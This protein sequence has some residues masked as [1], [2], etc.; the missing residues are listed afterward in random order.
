MSKQKTAHT[1][2]HGDCRELSVL[3][4]NSVD[5]IITSPPYWQLKDYGG[6]NQIGF[7][8]TYEEYINNLN[9]A[10]KE[11]H[12]VLDDGCRLCI[13][14]GDQFARSVYYGRYKVIPIHSEIIRFCETIGFDFMGQIIWQKTTTTNTTGG[15][16]IMG[17]FPYPRNGII[18]L[19]FEYI[20]LFKKQGN[21]KKPTLEQKEGARMTVAEW[22]SYFTGHWNFPGARQ[23]AHLAMFPEELPRRLIKMF[24]FPNETV[25]DPFAGSGTVA[26]VAK[27]LGRNSVSCEINEEYIPLIEKKIGLDFFSDIRNIS[28]TLPSCAELDAKIGELP[29]I[30][31]DVHELDKKTDVKKMPYGSKISAD[32]E[33]KRKDLFSVRRVI[34]TELLQLNNDVVVKLIGVKSDESNAAE[35]VRFLSDKFKGKRVFLKHDAVKYDSENHLLA[36]LY[37]ENKTFINAHLLK[38]KFAHV[39][40]SVP[41]G[42]L[43]KFNSLRYGGM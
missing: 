4:N 1:I 33:A 23:D 30:F 14:V 35:A 22:N 3:P 6:D 8:D 12:R 11:C 18:K 16:S 43:Q 7:N 24:S 15:A 9:V 17:S 39:D 37:L 20:L 21:A 32:S 27:E 42:L 26:K 34:S 36:Y 38:F 5:L 2:I 10:W 40:D 31:T 13:N 19:D 28:A 41:F 29:Y 25:F